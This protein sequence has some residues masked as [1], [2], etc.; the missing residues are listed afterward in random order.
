MALIAIEVGDRILDL[1]FRGRRRA[2]RHIIAEGA[3]MLI[4]YLEQVSRRKRQ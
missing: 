4:G 1:A 2:D 3:E